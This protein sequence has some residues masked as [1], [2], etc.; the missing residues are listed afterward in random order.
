[1]HKMCAPQTFCILCCIVFIVG[2]RKCIEPQKAR[3][4]TSNMHSK[5]VNKIIQ[6][7]SYI[8]CIRTACIYTQNPISSRTLLRKC[9]CRLVSSARIQSSFQLIRV[10]CDL[11]Q[12]CFNIENNTIRLLLTQI[13]TGIYCGGVNVGNTVRLRL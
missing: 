10:T 7:F 13:R 8:Q 9:S 1:M 4:Y 2:A 6:T 12:I 3:Q 5:I 11:N